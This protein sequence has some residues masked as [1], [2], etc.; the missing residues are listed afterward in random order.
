MSGDFLDA[1]RRLAGKTIRA[2]KKFLPSD[3]S[4]EARWDMSTG[5]IWRWFA[6]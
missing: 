4:D 1:A 2:R 3:L 6:P 5:G